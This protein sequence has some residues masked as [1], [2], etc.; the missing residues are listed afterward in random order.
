MDFA[1]DVVSG[2]WK[3]LHQADDGLGVEGEVFVGVAFPF[4]G[5]RLP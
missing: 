2:A 5:R 4:A 1:V 3:A